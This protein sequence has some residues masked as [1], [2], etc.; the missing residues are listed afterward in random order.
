MDDGIGATA[1]T[2]VI[3]VLEGTPGTLFGL[4]PTHRPLVEGQDPYYAGPRA[5]ADPS[6]P[7]TALGRGCGLPSVAVEGTW[8][9]LGVTIASSMGLQLPAATA[10]G[11]R[12]AAPAEA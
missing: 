5:V 10:A 2:D 9:D 8:A 11:M 12:P 1:R 3:A 4:S 6:A 7:S